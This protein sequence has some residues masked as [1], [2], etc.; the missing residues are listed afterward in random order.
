MVEYPSGPFGAAAPLAF[1]DSPPR[2]AIMKT[3]L[4]HSVATAFFLSLAAVPTDAAPPILGVRHVGEYAAIPWRK[5]GEPVPPGSRE[6]R[7]KDLNLSVASVNVHDDMPEDFYRH[8]NEQ[9]E[10]AARTGNIL[11]PRIHFWDGADRYTGPMRDIEVYWERLDTFLSKVDVGLLP[12]IVLA[13]ENVHYGGRPEVLAELYRRVKK[14]YDVPVWQWWSPMTAVPGSGGWIPSDGWIA[15]PYFKGGKEFRRFARK[16]V[17]TG[18]PFMLMPWAAQMDMEKGLTEEQWRAN[19]DQLDVAVEFNLPVA[20]F[21]VY[22]TSC[23]FGSDRGEPENEIGRINHWVWDYIERVRKLPEDYAGLPSADLGEGDALEI[24][25]DAEGSFVY[26]DDFSTSK[27][28]DEASMTGF[29]DFVLDGRRLSAR[30]FGGRP[31]DA[32]LVYHFTGDFNANHPAVYVNAIVSS[33]LDAKVSVALSADGTNWT[34]ETATGDSADGSVQ[35]ACTGEGD[36]RFANVR[37]FWARIHLSGK[38]GSKE[39]PPVQLEDL[40]IE[41]RVEPPADARVSL[42]ASPEMPGRVFYADDFRTRKYLFSTTRMH[43][44]HLEWSDG[45]LAVR[46]RPGGS[47]PAL[48]WQVVADRPVKEIA[49]RLE[50]R[51]NGRHLGSSLSLDVSLDGATWLHGINTSDQET[52]ANGWAAK[53]LSIDLSEDSRFEGIKRFFVRARLHAQAHP[54]VHPAQAGVITKLLVEGTSG[55]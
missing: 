44:E 25:P 16:Y 22:G 11:L 31:V 51:A 28:V 47:N 7:V 15:D 36:S 33:E 10:L 5:P 42:K 9:I 19:N 43:D 4:L 23:H 32:S 45:S 14:K 30:G 52:D 27:C 1:P 3:T 55:E 20:F 12:G 34:H 49:V 17:I 50:G 26:T 38:P 6:D 53:G 54:E 2:T 40:R 29:R 35:V 13:E 18:L 41:A 48:V 39:R 46:L 21:W 24:G 37:E 8:W